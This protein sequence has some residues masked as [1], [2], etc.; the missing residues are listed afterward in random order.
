MRA[1]SWIFRVKIRFLGHFL[2]SCTHWS[3]ESYCN[4]S[5]TFRKAKKEPQIYYW[6]VENDSTKEAVWEG[7]QVRFFF[8]SLLRKAQSDIQL[9]F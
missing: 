8:Q 4:Q 9:V 3:S 2:K 5:K 6:K 7:A 1:E